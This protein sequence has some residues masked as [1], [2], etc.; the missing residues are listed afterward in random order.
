MNLYPP[1]VT[2]STHISASNAVTFESPPPPPRYA[3]RPDI[4]LSGSGPLFFLPSSPHYTL[5]VSEK[6]F[7]LAAAQ[8]HTG[9]SFPA[10]KRFLGRNVIPMPLHRVISKA[11]YR[12]SSEGLVSCTVPRGCK[13]RL[14]GVRCGVWRSV[15]GEGSTYCIHTGDTRLSFTI[16]VLWESTIFGWSQS[17]PRYRLMRIQHAR[18]RLVISTDMSGGSVTAPPR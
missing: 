10:H 15:H 17:S 6:R 16:R 11:R 13:T 12:R 1:S 14:R 4:A 5:N 9:M 7:A 2:V 18:V 8:P 3:K